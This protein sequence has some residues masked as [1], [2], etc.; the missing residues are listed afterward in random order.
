M[1]RK[2]KKTI[3]LVS[4]VLLSALALMSA[5]MYFF[6]YEMVYENF[7]N[8]GYPT[9]LIYPLA[10]AKILGVI[11]LWTKKNATLREWAYAGFFYDFVLAIAAHLHARDGEFAPAL[12]ALILLI[13]S[14]IYKPKILTIT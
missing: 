14:Y 7:V 6:N 9:Y 10:I 1:T 3:Y 2:N 5:G 13:I 4:T 11:A 8:L 12:V